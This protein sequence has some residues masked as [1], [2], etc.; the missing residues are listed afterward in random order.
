ML[1]G[2]SAEDRGLTSRGHYYS[3]RVPILGHDEKSEQQSL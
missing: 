1:P 2:Q 3:K